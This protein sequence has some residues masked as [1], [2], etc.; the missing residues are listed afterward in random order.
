M[1]GVGSRLFLVGCDDESAGVGNG[2]AH[3]LQ[4]QV[5]R[6]QDRGNPLALGVEGGTPGLLHHVLREAFAQ[7]RAH[8][9]TGVGAPG[10][11]PRVG[12]EEN[13]AHDGVL[14]RVAVPVG[15]VGAGTPDTFVVF[16]VGDEGNWGSIG[17][18]GCSRQGESA[19]GLGEGFAHAI[20]PRQ[21]V[22]R[23]VDLVEN[24]E[25]TV[26]AGAGGVDSGVGPHLRVGDG[27]PVEVRSG[28]ALRVRKVGVDVDPETRGVGGPLAFEVLR[29]A[30]NRELVDDAAGN[31][32]GGERQRE[33]GFSGSGRRDRQKVARRTAHVAFEGVGLPGTQPT[34][35]CA[36]GRLAHLSEPF[37]PS[38][39]GQLRPFLPIESRSSLQVGHTGYWEASRV[40]IHTL[41]HR[42]TTGCP[43][44]IEELALSLRT[45]W[46]KRSPSPPVRS[47]LVSVR[48]SSPVEDAVEGPEGAEGPVGSSRALRMHSLYVPPTTPRQ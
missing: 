34:N 11:L 40:G 5:C 41:P 46:A 31:Q 48:S 15:V 30:H 23:V 25:G 45:K 26:G 7:A 14:E 1:A 39:N 18:E 28:D 22:S 19:R 10:H 29:G 2:A 6:T 42:A 37:P 32:F 27:N 21:G 44:T 43:V 9:V 38:E 24:D 36:P 13:G 20:A 16:R 47:R 4:A 12:H 8:L 17:A 33:G 3:L 35:R